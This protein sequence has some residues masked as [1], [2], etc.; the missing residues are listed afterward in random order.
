MNFINI[1]QL[2][3]SISVDILM[4]ILF[5]QV[6][7]YLNISYIMQVL[8]I[9]LILQIVNSFSMFLEIKYCKVH[10]LS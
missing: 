7:L 9:V 2:S 4:D 3:I 5:T 10:Y 1:I 8:V 6:V